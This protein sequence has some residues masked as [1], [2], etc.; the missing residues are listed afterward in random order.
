MK[1]NILVITADDAKFE[2][3]N[4]LLLSTKFSVSNIY[5]ISTIPDIH[6]LGQ[7]EVSVILVDNTRLEQA[8]IDAIHI[9]K[10]IMP[11]AAIV[12]IA[13]DQVREMHKAA[14]KA[15]AQDY[16]NIR[17]LEP[18]NLE[19]ALE[20]AI[21]RKHAS[22]DKDQLLREYK[23]QFEA[24]PIPMWIADAQTMQFLLVNDA[25]A[26]TYGYSKE[27]FYT[28][29]V[30]DIRPQ[31][32]LPAMLE[33][34]TKR[35]DN[36]F[37]AGYWRHQ[38]K[39]GTAFFVHVYSRATFFNGR[40]ARLCFAI[41]VHEKIIA[42]QKNRELLSELREQKNTL[43]D[44]LGSIGDAI[45]SR[46]SDTYALTYGNRSYYSMYGYEPGE[47]N[48]NKELILGSIHPDDRALFENAV[49]EVLT[50]GKTEIIYRF[51]HKTG[52]V[53][54]LKAD[55]FL[56]KGVDGA[57]DMINGITTDI[58]QEKKL[59][60]TILNTEQKLRATINNTKD[61]IWSVNSRLEIIFCNKP[62]QDFFHSL[63]GIELK[64]G[65]YVLGN[66]HSDEFI[67]GRKKDYERTF[68]GE[69]FTTYV[70]EIHDAEPRYFE[71]S[72]NPIRNH[73]NIIVGVNCIS[74]DVTEQKK[75]LIRINEQNEQL[76]QIAWIQSHRVRGPVACIMGLIPLFDGEASGSEHNKE[77]LHNLKEAA[78]E[79]D[80]M[81]R[82]IVAYTESMGMD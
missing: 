57:P 66:W 37:D 5:R 61:L 41:N 4:L 18:G 47:M 26:I 3:I 63:F 80:K 72:N 15:G 73:N 59:L 82:E 19:L 14:I 30:R 27:E 28:L 7:V 16:L 12:I 70:T 78:N 33:S 71:I 81:I 39:N 65:D 74:R 38:R 49:K 1:E 32:D 6:V 42:E 46:R 56:K 53:K 62:Y 55:C 79:L 10:R 48:P 36:N 17:T 22:F 60:E 13:P 40:D 34:Y 67:A 50:T 69:S 52:T 29:T 31:E 2:R 58:T 77:I 23:K 51:I 8:G 45:W 68:G 25:A 76:K 20:I 35:S 64:E 24:G 21:E 11:G 43:D 44:I 75:H 54:T 9:L